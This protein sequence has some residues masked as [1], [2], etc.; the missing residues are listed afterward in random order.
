MGDI[1]DYC[2]SRKKQ[3]IVECDA[4]AHHILGGST[5]TN[6]RGESLMEFL[7]SSNLNI[8]NQGNEPTFV[9][10]NRKEVIDLTLGTNKIGNL[11]SNWHV[12]D[13]PSL[14]DRRHICFQIGNITTEIVT[15][16]NPRRTNWES[17]KDNLNV[18]LEIISRNIRTIK[19]IDRSFVQLQRDISLSY[20][21]N[22]PAKTTRLPRN[23]LWWIKTLR[24]LRDKTRN[25]FN[26]A[27]RTGQWDNYKEALICYTVIKK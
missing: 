8:L 1:I 6:P 4:N 26:T 2:Q 14:S 27:K 7:V 16:R 12:S 13:E 17:Y 15:F 18:N 9:V 3:L 21:H 10:C 19:D 20:Y 24:G 23:A 22:C 11:V 5:G 25:I